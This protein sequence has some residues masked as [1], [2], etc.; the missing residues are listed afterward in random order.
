MMIGVLSDTHGNVM[1]VDRAFRFFADHG[2][3]TVFHLGDKCCDV[4][5]KDTQ[6]NMRVV[7]VAG[8]VDYPSDDNT[9]EEVVEID[10]ITFLLT[11]GHTF[12]VRS[13]LGPLTA[14]A[15]EK[16][17]QVA[18]YGHTHQPFNARVNGILVINPG[19][20]A[21]P[22]GA[23]QASVALIDTNEGRPLAAV[24]WL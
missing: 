13:S 14:K 12:D 16:G 6:Y 20:A 23:S 3:A 15:Q 8:N 4:L 22:R 7:C 17:C 24:H 21:Q 2:I 1:A 9:Y 5:D 10:G 18:L 19:S 11:H